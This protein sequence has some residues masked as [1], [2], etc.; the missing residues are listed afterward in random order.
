MHNY[1][2]TIM[3]LLSFNDEQVYK[4][5]QHKEAYQT[6]SECSYYLNSPQMREYIQTS[7][8]QHLCDNLVS[9]V[10]YGCMTK[11]AYIEYSTN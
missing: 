3:I 6:Y 8:R 5:V 1:F 7:L 9:I 11:D 4:Y 2:I 10:E